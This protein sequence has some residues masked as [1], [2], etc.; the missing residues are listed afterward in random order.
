MPRSSFCTLL[1][2]VFNHL[3]HPPTPLPS[4]SPWNAED[5]RA[6]VPLRLSGCVAVCSFWYVRWVFTCFYL[7][8]FSFFLLHPLSIPLILPHLLFFN[9]S[10][11][12]FLLGSII[13]LIMP[14][15]CDHSFD[16]GDIIRLMAW[17]FRPNNSPPPRYISYT[18]MTYTRLNG[19]SVFLC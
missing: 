2:G 1:I 8:F 15:L 17:L 9:T 16:T 14:V 5:G 3:S 19:V 7:P 4:F 12:F 13:L 18:R 10:P 6:Y 11:V